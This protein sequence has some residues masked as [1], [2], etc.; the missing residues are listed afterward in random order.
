MKE[1]RDRQTDGRTEQDTI[2]ETKL[3]SGCSKTDK[4][5]LHMHQ[6]IRYIK[7]FNFFVALNCLFACIYSLFQK[8]CPKKNQPKAP[9]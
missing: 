4:Y 6:R 1:K 9:S 8:Y 3:K 7:T 5:A 2:H